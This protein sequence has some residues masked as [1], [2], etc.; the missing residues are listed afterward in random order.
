MGTDQNRIDLSQ[1]ENTKGFNAKLGFTLKD[2][3]FLE[4]E[5]NNLQN[6]YWAESLYSGAIAAHVKLDILTVI[7][8]G[9]YLMPL[10]FWGVQPFV[11]AGAGGLYYSAENYYFE[12]GSSSLDYRHDFQPCIK[13][14]LGAEYPISNTIAIAAEASYVK[15]FLRLDYVSY[16]NYGLNVLFYF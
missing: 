7:L 1:M 8:S 14:G 4:A 3:L 13:V 9:K 16:Y 6:F 15:A 12:F 2:D 5:I 11:T 10:D